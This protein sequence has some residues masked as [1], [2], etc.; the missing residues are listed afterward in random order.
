[1]NEP[2]LPD[3]D[4]VVDSPPIPEPDTRPPEEK[5]DGGEIPKK[6]P[7]VDGEE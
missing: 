2:V 7:Q 5:Y 1:M 4:V 6:S 3:P